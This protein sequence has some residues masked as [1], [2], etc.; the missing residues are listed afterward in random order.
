MKLSQLSYHL[1]ENLIANS[2]I[3]PRDHSKLMVINRRDNS[4]THKQ[5]YD[6]LEILTPNDVLVFNQTKVFPARIFTKKDSGKEIEILLT[7]QIGVNTWKAIHKSKL[8]AG[9]TLHFPEATAKVLQKLDR[10]IELQ[11]DVKD[12]WT[13]LYRHG[14]T[15]LPPYI[16]KDMDEVSAREKYQTVYAKD[17]GSV[18]A[19]TAGFHFTEELLKKLEDKGIEMEYVTLHVGLGTFLPV[20]TEDLSEHIMHSEHY[21]LDL[22][23]AQRLNNAKKTGKRIISVGT[24]TT[25]VLETCS[26]NGTLIEQSGDTS[27]F[28]YPPYKFQF[29]DALITNFHLPHSTLL[30][31]VSAFVSE[32]NTSSEFT[33]F[34]SSL[35]GKAYLSAIENNYRFYSFGD[36]SIIL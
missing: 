21:Q 4:I 12:F 20:K 7:T 25:R 27:I 29:V 5:F 32:P 2:P 11:F 1:P 8:R 13:W 24:T 3:E 23:T 6:L 15:P 36:S 16:K 28:I 35:M 9:D 31:L 17:Q 30:A 33:N 34:K 26:K 18:A 10:E 14:Q 22:Q 19:P